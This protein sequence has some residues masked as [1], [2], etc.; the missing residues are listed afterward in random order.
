MLAQLP[1]LLLCLEQRLRPPLQPR[2][3]LNLAYCHP[4]PPP[5]QSSAAL[6]FGLRYPLQTSEM[7]GGGGEL[8]RCKATPERESLG[9]IPLPLPSGTGVPSG[10]TQGECETEDLVLPMAGQSNSRV[11]ASPE[12]LTE[13]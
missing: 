7:E 9:K 2:G 11:R 1:G 3:A 5:P 10:A 8:A 4:P 12:K 6:L 13:P